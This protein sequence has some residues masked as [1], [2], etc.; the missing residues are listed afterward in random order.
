MCVSQVPG[1][2]EWLSILSGPAI[3]SGIDVYIFYNYPKIKKVGI[4]GWSVVLILIW[5]MANGP[6]K[7]VWC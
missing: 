7:A 4:I 1:W 6:R 3:I 5:L 2:F